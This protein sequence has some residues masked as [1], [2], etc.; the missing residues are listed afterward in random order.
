M[1]R[2]QYAVY[3]I[4]ALLVVNVFTIGYLSMRVSALSGE[5]AELQQTQTKLTKIAIHTHTRTDNVS[6]TEIDP[7]TGHM[8][9]HDEL[10]DTGVIIRYT[11]QPIPGGS[12]YVSASA[13][14]AAVSTQKSFVNAKRAVDA[15][16]YDP[17]VTGMAITIYNEKG[18]SNLHGRSAGLSI[19]R[20]YAS[21]DPRY[22]INKSVV[23]TGDIQPSG[24]IETVNFIGMKARAAA[25]NGYDV[26]VVPKT[27]QDFAVD[28]IRVVQVKMLRTALKYGLDPVNNTAS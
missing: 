18:W 24:R 17:A 11:Y 2:S 4:V 16:R 27:Y 1:K 12:V 25:Q 22:V 19:A 26:I 20:M 21:T 28:G 6:T 10:S 8:L 9:A 23:L 14:P 15:S 13:L 3:A 5:V 7:R